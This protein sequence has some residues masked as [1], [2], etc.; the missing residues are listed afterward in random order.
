MDIYIPK[1]KIL[2]KPQLVNILRQNL[3]RPRSNRILILNPLEKCH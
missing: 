3:N 1:A 2:R